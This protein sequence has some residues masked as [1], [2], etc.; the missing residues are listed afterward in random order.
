MTWTTPTHPRKKLTAASL[1]ELSQRNI[2]LP[3]TAKT[4]GGN[5][6]DV[7]GLD[8]QAPAGPDS[9]SSHQSTVLGKRQLLSRAV[10]VGD[11]G[12]DQSPL[13][14]EVTSVIDLAET[15]PFQ[16]KYPYVRRSLA[17][18]TSSDQSSAYRGRVNGVIIVVPS[19][20]G[21]YQRF[22]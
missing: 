22:S 4:E 18:I 1:L 11:T 7:T 6:Q 14:T 3:A 13:H 20:Q 8:N 2:H 5:I 16:I 17:N 12:D 19:S 10:E 21:P 15:F 9:T